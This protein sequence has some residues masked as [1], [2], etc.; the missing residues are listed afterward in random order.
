MAGRAWSAK[1][2]AAA[3][4]TQRKMQR[5]TQLETRPARD[6]ARSA[7]E[8]QTGGCKGIFSCLFSCQSSLTG[9]CCVSLARMR[10]LLESLLESSRCRAI[11]RI[12]LSSLCRFCCQSC[13]QFWLCKHNCQFCSMHID[14]QRPLRGSFGSSTS[15]LPR[16]ERLGRRGGLGATRGAGRGRATRRQPSLTCSFRKPFFLGKGVNIYASSRTLIRHLDESLPDL[17]FENLAHHDPCHDRLW[18]WPEP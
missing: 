2:L 4:A 10:S 7:A 11:W 18:A 1:N 17:F 5:E 15:R 16:W 3:P 6:V 14:R 9:R 8:V 12:T 13:C